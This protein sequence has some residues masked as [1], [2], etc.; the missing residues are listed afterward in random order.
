[1][2]VYQFNT[3]YAMNILIKLK[4]YLRKNHQKTPLNA[5]S[6]HPILLPTFTAI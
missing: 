6:I 5:L 1:M 3:K 2:E 4:L